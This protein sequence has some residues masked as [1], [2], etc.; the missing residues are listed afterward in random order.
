MATMNRT[1]NSATITVSPTKLIRAP[2]SK[3][4]PAPT[5]KVLE[6]QEPRRTRRTTR[7]KSPL[8]LQFQDVEDSDGDYEEEN[9]DTA[10]TLE[11]LVVLVKD[12]KKTIDQQNKSIQEAQTELKELKEEQQQVKEQNNE[13]KDEICMLRDQV[14]SLS[15]SLPSAPSWAS[16]VANRTGSGSVR[17]APEGNL[18]RNLPHAWAVT[19]MLH[20]TIDVSRVTEEDTDKTS[21]SAIRAIVEKEIRASNGQ[22]K[23]RCQAVTRDA[24]NTSRV[25]I[26]CRDETEQLMVKRAVETKITTGVRVLGDELYPIKVDNVN[27]LAVLDENGEIRPGAA[28][29]LGQENDTTVA[30]IGWLSKKNVPK[31]YGSMVAYVTKNSDAR[32]LLK[33]GYFHVAGE[34]GYTRVFERRTGPKQ[35]Y[36]CQEIGHKAYQCENAQKC[37]RCAGEG[38]RHGE[39]TNT[40]LK[41]IPCGGPHE[42]FSK[43]CRKLYPSQT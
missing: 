43:N 1:P 3:R 9:E 21:P 8:R 34:S 31:A 32:R 16:I 41:C 37:A 4:P 14:G 28:E 15:A 25:K 6:N 22:S 12:L 18:A 26:A 5:A 35:C 17:Q 33:E 36:N 29:A 20:C 38:H 13:L 30:K 11:E 40:I 42:S 27:R 39:C 23:W 7:T 2:R 19:D 24:K 10:N